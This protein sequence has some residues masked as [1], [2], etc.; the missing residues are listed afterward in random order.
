[1]ICNGRRVQVSSP[2]VPMSQC[3]S[4]AAVAALA[5]RNPSLIL[6]MLPP[7]SALL[8]SAADAVA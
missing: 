1:M 7:R 4:S 5:S 6:M 8:K 3:F 2:S